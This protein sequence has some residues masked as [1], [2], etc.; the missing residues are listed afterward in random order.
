MADST[1]L[2]TTAKRRPPNAGKGRTKGIP[3]KFTG[4]IKEMILGALGDAHP[5]GGQAYLADQAIKNPVAFMGLVGKVGDVGIA[6]KAIE[7][8]L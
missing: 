4:T 2:A 1:L 8:A 6:G 7:L 5:E 3:N